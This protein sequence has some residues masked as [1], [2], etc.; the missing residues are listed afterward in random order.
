M[1]SLRREGDLLGELLDLCVRE[2]VKLGRIEAIGS[3]QRARLGYYHQKSREYRHFALNEPLEIS[4]LIGNISLKDGQPFVHAHVILSN[5]R[6][7]TWGGHLASGT[8]VFACEYTVEVFGGMEF[9]R[10]HDEGT[11]LHLWHGE[12][13]R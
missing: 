6:G 12:D 10:L 8:I 1:G 4:S 9:T 2:S 11:G 13:E 7:K 3:V 5:A